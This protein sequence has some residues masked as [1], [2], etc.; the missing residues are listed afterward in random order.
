MATTVTPNRASQSADSA[1][2]LVVFGTSAGELEVYSFDLA[3]A[4]E[5]H[6]N[7]KLS[8]VTNLDCSQG[9]AS[10]GS[11]LAMARVDDQ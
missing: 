7:R 9:T 3:A 8:M 6:L 5:N 10:E 1:H 2:Y 4:T 11:V